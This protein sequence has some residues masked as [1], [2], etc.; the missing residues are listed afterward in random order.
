MGTP[1]MKAFV[2]A[3]WIEDV[4]LWLLKVRFEVGNRIGLSPISVSIFY[5]SSN[6]DIELLFIN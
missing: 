6:L 1:V 4:R 5:L 2:F 3:R